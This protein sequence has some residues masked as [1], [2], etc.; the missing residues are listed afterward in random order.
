MPT[1]LKLKRHAVG[2]AL[3]IVTAGLT[4]CY[5]GPR[6]YAY[7]APGYGYHQGYYAGSA[8]G[9]GRDGGRW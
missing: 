1:F 6:P 2:V 5:Y 9:Y 8:Y 4:G 3:L 7:A